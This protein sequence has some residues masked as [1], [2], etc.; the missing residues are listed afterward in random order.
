MSGLRWTFLY[1]FKKSPV[2]EQ[3]GPVQGG[4]FVNDDDYF[5]IKMYKN[6]AGVVTTTIEKVKKLF[7]VFKYKYSFNREDVE[8]IFSIKKSRA[9]KII[10]KLL[11][12]GLIEDAEPTKY[13][14][15]K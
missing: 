4:N 2:F 1:V 10:S 8:K 14:F 12:L 6:L 15:K 5:M 3:K 13:K 7:E 9:S 11:N